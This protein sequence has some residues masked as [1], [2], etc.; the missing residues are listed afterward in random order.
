MLAVSSQSTLEIR[1]PNATRPWQHVLESLSGYLCLGQKL[2]EGR[3][4]F[5]DAWNFGPEAEG[6]RSVVEVLTRLRA[7]W[8]ALS[9]RVTEQ[10]QPNEAGLLHLES[11]KAR[12]QLGWKPVWSLGDGDRKST[13]LNS[14]H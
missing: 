2:L 4:E 5:G 3:K 7:S 9:W 14:S 11:T 1:S 10:A 12:H 8:P 6:N 13:R